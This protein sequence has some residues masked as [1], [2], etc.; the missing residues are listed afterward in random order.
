MNLVSVMPQRYLICA[1][2][3]PKFPNMLTGRFLEDGRAN[4][5]TSIALRA[6]VFSAATFVLSSVATSPPRAGFCFSGSRLRAGSG[7]FRDIRSE[8]ELVYC[9]GRKLS[10]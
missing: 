4:G 7:H 5:S 3:A 9:V 10:A 2:P 1:G 8:G 6:R